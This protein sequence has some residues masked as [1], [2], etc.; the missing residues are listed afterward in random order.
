MKTSLEGPL[1]IL[2]CVNSI[3]VL[4]LCKIILLNIQKHCSLSNRLI[5][6]ILWKIHSFLLFGM[7]ILSLLNEVHS[8]RSFNFYI[9]L[10]PFVCFSVIFSYMQKKWEKRQGLEATKEIIYFFIHLIIYLFIY[11]LWKP[12]LENNLVKKEKQEH[13]SLSLRFLV[14]VLV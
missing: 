9:A 6:I 5:Y 1:H 10:S 11:V 4:S 7:V 13:F 8:A 14:A 2:C 12:R 3:S